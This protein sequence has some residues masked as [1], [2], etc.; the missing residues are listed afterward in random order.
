[1]FNDIHSCST[2]Q[3]CFSMAKDDSIKDIFIILHECKL[4]LKE[5]ELLA[6]KRAFL[7]ILQFYSRFTVSY[8]YECM[9]FN[10]RDTKSFLM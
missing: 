1:M 2:S 5:N 3:S 8:L 4:V 6:K 10:R 9:C 7:Y